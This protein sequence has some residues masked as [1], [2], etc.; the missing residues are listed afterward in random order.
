M[1]K[2]STDSYSKLDILFS[3]HLSCQGL[4]TR[5]KWIQTSS[6]LQK[7][8]QR[9]SKGLCV[10]LQQDGNFPLKGG[11]SGQT[12]ISLVRLTSAYVNPGLW[13]VNLAVLC[14]LPLICSDTKGKLAIESECK[15][16]LT[17]YNFLILSQ[18]MQN[19]QIVIITSLCFE[20]ES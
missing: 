20:S 18:I 9:L 5:Y 4:F 12:P 14:Y 19:F 3:P 15:Y 7:T 13:L 1:V 16:I 6:S 8:R 17:W 2:N 10:T 11:T